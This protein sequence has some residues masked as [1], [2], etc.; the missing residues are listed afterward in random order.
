MKVSWLPGVILVLGVVLITAHFWGSLL[1]K[2]EGFL[3]QDI[4][5]QVL[6]NT[7]DEQQETPINETQAAQYYRALLVFISKDFSKGLK[8]VHDLNKR[9][10]GKPFKIPDDFDPR[11]ITDNYKNP[12]AGI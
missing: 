12:I 6:Q 3:N 10:Y 9:V 8:I 1:S 2:K 5:Q 7:A 11:K 4:L